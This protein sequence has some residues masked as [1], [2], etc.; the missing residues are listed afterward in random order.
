MHADDHMCGSMEIFNMRDRVLQ[1]AQG[2]YHGFVVVIPR[3][4]LPPS[5]SL[6]LSL[7]PSL[8]SASLS[9]SRLPLSLSL[10]LS[11][12][13]LSLSLCLSLFL[14]LSLSR[15]SLSLSASLFL[16]L[17]LPSAKKASRHIF[18]ANPGIS[19]P[20]TPHI[21]HLSSYSILP[22]DT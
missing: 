3:P 19:C 12:S 20:A 6:S 18:P 13:R 11:L 16:Y 15:P 5:L 1:I 4:S 9:L 7:S 10:V 21:W 22:R 14:T 8:T 2:W 17:S